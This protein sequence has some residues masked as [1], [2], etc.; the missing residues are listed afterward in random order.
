MLADL[1]RGE[2]PHFYYSCLCPWL[3]LTSITQACVFESHLESAYSHLEKTT[4]HKYFCST[5]EKKRSSTG[6]KRLKR[7]KSD[8]SHK[9]SFACSS[10]PILNIS[11]L[12]RWC[13]EVDGISLGAIHTYLYVGGDLIDKAGLREAGLDLFEGDLLPC[14]GKLSPG[15]PFFFLP[16]GIRKQTLFFPLGLAGAKRDARGLI[17][18]L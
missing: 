13:L 9:S 12:G 11:L 3:S 14:L 2:S 7:C 16:R 18:F 1:P 8:T 4:K 5:Q 6:S 10:A 17:S 15:M